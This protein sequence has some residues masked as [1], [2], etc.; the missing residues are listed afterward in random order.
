MKTSGFFFDIPGELI[1]QY[2]PAERG[3]SR[4]MVLD[5][6][7]GKREHRM[8]EE[9]PLILSGPGFR[10][11]GGPPLLVFNN[12]RVRKARLL[13]IS[14]AA[15][16]TVEFLL[17]NRIDSRTW[18]TMTGRTKRRRPGSR[19]RFPDGREGEIVPPPPGMSGEGFRYLRFDSPIDDSW[20]DIHGH[21][22][23]PPYINRNDEGL[24]AERY[25]TVYSDRNA[26]ETLG[27]GASAAAPTAGLHF[28]EQL[29]AALDTAGIGR[30]FVT[31]HVGPG[32][33]LPVR[34]EHIED[35]VMH[36]EV[37]SI[38]GETA[39]RINAARAEG[40][41]I[42]AVG[43]TSVRT[44]ESA[45]GAGETGVPAGEGSTSVF[46]YPGYRFRMVDALFTNFHTPGSTLLMLAAAF[47]GR[48]LILD[49]YAE[50]IRKGYRFF[51]YGD[52]MLLF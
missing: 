1:A 52:A 24:D 30:V 33:F 3:K 25:Q 17:L 34:T 26:A 9:L 11:P 7:G 38:N 15:G 20:L 49:S 50:A 13:G 45:A 42:V 40:R 37:Y 48:E 39:R 19:Y 27:P 35:H 36:E 14:L 44:L 43:T 10:G 23:L 31:L 28:T 12:S 4:L 47:A 21:I 51:S 32:T 29:L 46:I 6:A 5:T 2:P 18:R 41:K 8:V 22:P 16:G